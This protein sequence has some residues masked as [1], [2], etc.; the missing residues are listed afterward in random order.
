MAI[1]LKT[2]IYLSFS[3]LNYIFLD[4]FARIRDLEND[5]LFIEI[6]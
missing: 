1:F 3:I 6:G 5:F 4:K 2:F